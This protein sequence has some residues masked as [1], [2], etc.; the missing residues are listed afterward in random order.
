MS[1]FKMPNNAPSPGNAAP[2]APQAR[3]LATPQP[4]AP[5]PAAA[6]KPAPTQPSMPA[7]DPKATAA[8][9]AQASTFTRT[10]APAQRPV[11]STKSEAPK[12]QKGPTASRQPRHVRRG[13]SGQGQGIW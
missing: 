7:M 9:R 13:R 2:A 4:A 6:A 11:G 12:A 1:Q 5:K 3:P 10:T 8:A